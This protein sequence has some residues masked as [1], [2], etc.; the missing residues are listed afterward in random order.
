MLPCATTKGTGFFPLHFSR[1]VPQFDIAFTITV[2]A[3]SSRFLMGVH[4]WEKEII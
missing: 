2:G 3:G 4:R 1:R